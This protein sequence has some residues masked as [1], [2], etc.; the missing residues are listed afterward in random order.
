MGESA[1]DSAGGSAAEDQRASSDGAAQGANRTQVRT[2]AV[3]RTGSVFVVSKDLEAARARVDRLLAR[4]DGYIAEERSG[5]DADGRPRSSTLTLRVP[6]PAFDDVM[7]ELA[8]LG[9]LEEATRDARD[10]TTEV[11]DVDSRVSTQQASLDRLES[12]LGQ[13]TDIQD[14]IRLEAEI[15]RR[16]AELES[17]KAQQAYLADQTSLATVTLHLT[18]PPAVVEPPDALDDAGFLAGL[19]NGWEALRIVLVG[20]ATVAGALLPFLVAGAVV[21]VPVWL[22]ARS[23]VRRRAAAPP[24]TPV[25]DGS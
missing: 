8:G 4:T 1:P 19:R 13:A 25:K 21:A 5:N 16:Q 24:P 6:E 2:R 20:A 14:V 9:R 23:L 17:L 10:V 11:I 22:L 7:A 18:A 3:I 15:S 12:F